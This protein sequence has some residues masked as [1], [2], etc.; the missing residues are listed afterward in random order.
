MVFEVVECI[1]ACIVKEYKGGDV[2]IVYGG[3]RGHVLMV[4]FDWFLSRLT[5]QL[6]S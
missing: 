5:I 6:M 1:A 2:L 3:D 4:T